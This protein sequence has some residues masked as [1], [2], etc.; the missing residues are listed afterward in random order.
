LIGVA[1]N[2]ILWFLRFIVVACAGL[3]IGL[4]F[5]WAIRAWFVSEVSEREPFLASWAPFLFVVKFSNVWHIQDNT[6]VEKVGEKVH[7]NNFENLL[8][9]FPKYW[10]CN[11][12]EALRSPARAPK[13]ILEPHDGVRLTVTSFGDVEGDARGQVARNEDLN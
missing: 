11:Y 2:A 7:K 1:S 8:T 12:R 10:Y 6:V 13:T 9:K 5:A 4:F 3:A